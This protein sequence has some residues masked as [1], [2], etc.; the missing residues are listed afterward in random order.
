M[1]GGGD[2]AKKMTMEMRLPKLNR[3][4]IFSQN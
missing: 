3:I 4:A 1:N 2:K